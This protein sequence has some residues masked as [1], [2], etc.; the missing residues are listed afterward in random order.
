M[1]RIYDKNIVAKE[2]FNV[3]LSAEDVQTI[4]NGNL[5]IDHPDLR[6]E[7]CVILEE[8]YPLNYPTYDIVKETIREMTIYERYQHGLYALSY[9]EVEYQGDIR[10]LS[11]GEYLENG[12]IKSIPK[13]EGTK[14]EWNWET[15]EWEEKAT[16]LEI[17]QAQ[18]AEYEG[19]DTVSTVREMEQIDKA[20]ADE[21]VTMLI[22]LRNIAYSLSEQE[23]KAVGYSI[24]PL[25]KPSKELKE[26]LNKRKIIKER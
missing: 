13:P 20:M 4:L 10:V 8:E 23:A 9:N 2:L 19:M 11:D 1:F 14:I 5:F 15:H 6:E 24:I 26:Y 17:V 22:D 25:P 12:E 7:D 18:Y 16:M 3:N 21:F